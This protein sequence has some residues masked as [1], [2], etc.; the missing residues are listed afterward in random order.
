MP[1]PRPSRTVDENHRHPPTAETLPFW[2][3][4]PQFLRFPLQKEPLLHAILLS[5]WSLMVF[6]PPTLLLAPLI[7]LWVI[8]R[9]AFKIAA[10]ASVGIT[11][12]ADYPHNLHQDEWAGL[13]WRLFVVMLVHF[14]AHL[15]LAAIGVAALIAGC[16]L[17]A[18][19]IPATLMVLIIRK[20]LL[21]ALNPL[22][23]WL[24]IAHIGSA[25]LLLCFF[26][27]LLLQ[28]LPWL[29]ALLVFVMPRALVLPCMVFTFIYG[30]WVLASMIGYVIYQY[31]QELDV[32]PLDELEKT[33]VA[34]V[35]PD[36]DVAEARWRDAQ[37]EQW[38]QQGDLPR[39]LAAARDWLGKSSDR[40]AI[41]ADHRR[42]HRLLLHAGQVQTLT[43]HAQQ[44]ISLLLQA[45]CKD[46][47]LKVWKTCRKHEKNFQPDTPEATLTLA[48]H[49]WNIRQAAVPA[50]LLLQGFAKRFPQC[51]SIPQALELMVH[52]LHT[53]LQDHARAQQVLAHM[54]QHWPKHPSTHKATHVVHFSEK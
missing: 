16:I 39:A 46:E 27:W 22:H 41:L 3:Q 15:K 9:Y 53:G 17:S 43:E 1:L 2:R 10:L 23:L 28:G 5:L 26:L 31:R 6:F 40:Q 19:L 12:C 21:S 54:K 34:A 11:R 32:V 48:E 44:L 37:V 13:P 52:A 49:A 45:L 36:P 4:L 20:S 29:G 47:A 18:L 30:I 25:Y 8:S 51:A 14:M 7:L 35:P 33:N 42:Y 50:L 38:L 24:T